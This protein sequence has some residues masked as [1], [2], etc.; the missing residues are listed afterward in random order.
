MVGKTP[1]VMVHSERADESTR[2]VQTPKQIYNFPPAFPWFV[3]VIPPAL[4]SQ[5]P[6]S[7]K[8]QISLVMPAS[9]TE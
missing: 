1:N 5:A 6:V 8:N 3:V 7:M 2:H 9:Q 4:G